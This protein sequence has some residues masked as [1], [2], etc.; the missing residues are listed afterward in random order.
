L[1]VAIQDAVG[2]LDYHLHQFELINP[3]TGIK[4]GIGIPDEDFPSDI[5][6]LPSWR[7]KIAEW[8]TLENRSAACIYDFGDYWY[9]A[10]KLENIWLFFTFAGRNLI[11][12]AKFK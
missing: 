5:V 4:V 3:S 6:I 2:W 10:V 11:I 7:E 8:F 1:H 12:L 9:H